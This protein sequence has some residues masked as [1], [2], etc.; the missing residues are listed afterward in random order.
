MNRIVASAFFLFF[1][2]F[3]A[4]FSEKSYTIELDARQRECYF[5]HFKKSTD[6]K[7][8]TFEYQVLDGGDFQIDTSLHTPGGNLI[9]AD[10][11]KAENTHSFV[12]HEDGDY[13][14][15]FDNGVSAYYDKVVFFSFDKEENEDRD[16]G[17]DDDDEEDDYF[18]NLVSDEFK[19]VNE[20]DGKV[21][22]FKYRVERIHTKIEVIGKFQTA[23]RS[24]E[25][26][27]RH[28]AE[29]NFE[30]VNFWSAANLFA[31]LFVLIVQV[32]AI[33]AL[34]DEKSYL[35]SLLNKFI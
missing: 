21:N 8:I 2:S 14:V 7:K 26:R 4:T 9:I 29:R 31:L 34:F 5:E 10:Y 23:I 28:L 6:D 13:Q 3:D 16:G 24:Q 25:S 32:F 20:Y 19:D 15:C 12:P 30:R 35:N 11:K 1:T 33:Q 17:D 18:K 22:D 27:D